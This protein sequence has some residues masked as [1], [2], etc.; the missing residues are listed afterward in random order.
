[1]SLGNWLKYCP[2][3]HINTLTTEQVEKKKPCIN[4]QIE[5]AKTL[6]ERL[7]AVEKKREFNS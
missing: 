5:H 7:D 4:C 6:K 3:C 1:M 2:I